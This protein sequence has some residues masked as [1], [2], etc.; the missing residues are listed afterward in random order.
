MLAVNNISVR[1]AIP[2]ITALIMSVPA[3]TVATAV[4][5]SARIAV[6]IAT[7]VTIISVLTA[8]PVWSVQRVTAGVVNVITAVIA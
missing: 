2:A 7:T 3:E 6:S 1:I 5:L 8:N 4:L